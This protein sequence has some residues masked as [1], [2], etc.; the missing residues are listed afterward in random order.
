MKRFCLAI[1]FI[2]CFSVWTNKSDCEEINLISANSIINNLKTKIAKEPNNTEDR[3]ELGVMYFQLQEYAKA[4]QYFEETLGIDNDNAI[5]HYNLGK[6]LIILGGKDEGVSE[7]EKSLKLGLDN[8]NVYRT[9]SVE[10]FEKRDLEKALN[11]HKNIQR[12]EPNNDSAYFD[13]GVI[14]IGLRDG[15]KARKEFETRMNTIHNWKI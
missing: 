6:T 7:C 13:A 15:W 4:R 12:L 11:M 1:V 14:Y 5:A 10:Y 2:L 8:I 3:I 9:L